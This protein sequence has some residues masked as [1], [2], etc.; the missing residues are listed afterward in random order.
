MDALASQ[1][2]G[3]AKAASDSAA[4]ADQA[5]K[6]VETARAEVADKSA[7]AAA[8]ADAAK[9]SA[10][11]AA[12]AAKS[13]L[14]APKPAPTPTPAPVATPEPTPTPTP[15]PS[16]AADSGP[17]TAAELDATTPL[18]P[19]RCEADMLFVLN[20]TSLQFA[21]GKATL[22]P[23]SG[24]TLD[25]LAKLAGRCPDAK[26][27]VSGFTDNLGPADVNKY[28]SKQ[29]AD[30]VVA[31]LVRRG[32]PAARLTGVGYGADRPV[33]PNDT[34]AGRAKNRRIEMHVK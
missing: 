28:I 23:A 5:A 4:T 13:A 17:P 21:L 9:K 34:E 2:A 29:R 14:D 19:P 24:P 25:Q 22:A 6:A 33:A 12:A 15:T 31:A 20:S 32:V 10:D 1:A 26:L 7:A 18:T 27:E 11:E 16:P 30:A 8:A 3:S